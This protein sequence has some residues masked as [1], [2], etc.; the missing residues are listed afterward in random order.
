MYQ[1]LYVPA[2]NSPHSNASVQLCIALGEALEARVVGSHVYAA[3]L[4]DIRFKQMEF[5]LPD[6]YKDDVELEKQRLIHD[7]LIA[8]GLHL[9]SDSYL[10]RMGELAEEAGLVFE[11][12][13]FDGRNFTQIVK[14]IQDSDYDLVIMGVLGQGAV[15]GSQV[16]SV[17]KRVLRR[18][19]RD[20]IV[21]RDPERANL[22][23]EGAITVLIDGSKAAYGALRAACW[24]AGASGRRLE[25][26]TVLPDDDEAEETLLQAHLEVSRKYARKQGIRAVTTLMDGAVIPTLLA[27]IERT[28]PWLVALGRTGIDSESG[29]LDLGSVT[30]ALLRSASSHLLVGGSKI[31]PATQSNA[32][33]I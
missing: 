29:A 17:C 20:T 12:K 19:A 32:I 14:D 2:D 15:R 9:I 22:R 6:E 18:T 16:G 10:D 11:R 1:N 28:R 26:L 5:T 23:G 27:H 8:R 13:H 21:I 25:L 31:L 30:E 24:M 4:H 33:A 7:S 3:K